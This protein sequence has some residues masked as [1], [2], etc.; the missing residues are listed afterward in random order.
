MA[1]IKKNSKPSIANLKQYNNIT[2]T[3]YFE[4]Q[5]SVTSPSN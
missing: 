5:F 4:A 2:E 3:A 1:P